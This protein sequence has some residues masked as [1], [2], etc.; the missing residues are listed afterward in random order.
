MYN[1]T[2]TNGA[3]SGVILPSEALN[4]NGTWIEYDIPGYRTLGV[5]GR[6]VSESEI[7]DIQ[8]GLTDGTRYQ[9]SRTPSRVLTIHYQLVSSTNEGFRESFNRLN[10]LLGAEQA[11]LT[12][13]DEPDKFFIGTKSGVGEVPK[14]KN[15]IVSEFSIYCADPFKYSTE[16]FTVPIQGNAFAFYYDGTQKS[17]PILEAEIRG[18]NGFIGFVNQ[19]GKILQFGNP[20]EA[21]G[22]KVENSGTLIN[23]IFNNANALNG[24][25]RN[26]ANIGSTPVGTVAINTGRGELSASNY[27]SGSAYFGPSISRIIPADKNGHVGAKN[28]TLDWTLYFAIFN[29][30]DIGRMIFALADKNRKHVAKLYLHKNSQGTN[31]AMLSFDVWDRRVRDMD[32]PHISTTNKITGAGHGKMSISKF[33]STV[34]FE[35]EGKKYPFT[36]PEVRDVEVHEVMVKFEAWGNLQKMSANALKRIRFISH[37][38]SA[39]HNIP[40]R[41]QNR[42]VLSADCNDRS[43]SV[44]EVRENGLGALGNDWEEF[45]LKPGINEIQCLY[46]TWAQQPSFDLKYRKVWL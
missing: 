8:I 34:T 46:S 4:F 38:V 12:F 36:V 10:A 20:E 33:G 41:F 45:Y 44:N 30:L 39:W 35:I 42:D 17:F 18:E 7:R 3:Q 29:N 13:N 16:V 11:R 5:S 24:W 15:R 9:G 19:D 37:S 6:E 22:E 25:E 23:T 40:N 1:F 32:V 27:G 31:A 28:C 43:V 2:N 26:R 21:D 14:G